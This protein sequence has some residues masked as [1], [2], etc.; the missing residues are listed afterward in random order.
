MSTGLPYQ[1][2]V[3]MLNF[4][5]PGFA[6]PF[7]FTGGPSFQPFGGGFPGA[8]PTGFGHQ[9]NPFVQIPFQAQFALSNPLAT[10]GAGF[11]G[12]S[13][14]IGQA[15]T[16]LPMGINPIGVRFGNYGFGNYGIDPRLALIAGQHAGFSDPNVVPYGIG[17][18]SFVDPI[19]SLLSQQHNQVNPLVAS[20]LQQQQPPI[21]S[22]IGN[23]QGSNLPSFVQTP[24]VSM[25]QWTDPYRAI[26][27]TQLLSQIAT[28]PLYQFQRPSEGW[29]V[30]LGAASINPLA[31]AFCG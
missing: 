2:E 4:A 24:S 28:N 11:G 10:I 14:W 8:F 1:Q 19:V 6:N 20:L 30:P 23:Q 21:R 27:E 17:A 25:G 5:R 12:I 18:Q 13:P 9:T 31:A 7:Q 3:A 15:M 16:N 26:L 22:L 29:S